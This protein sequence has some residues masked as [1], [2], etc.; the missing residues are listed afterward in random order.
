M[1]RLPIIVLALSGALLAG[2]SFAQ[3]VPGQYV[4]PIEGYVNLSAGFCDFRTRHYHG[5]IDLSTGGQEG[6][7]IRA[8]D[9][10]WVSRVSVGFW[11]YGKAIYIQMTDGRIA[12]YGHLSEL[13]DKIQK[14][15]EDEQYRSHRYQQNLF[16]ER[17]QIPIARGE[18]IGKSGQT[19]AGPPHLH[20]EIRTGDNKPL[21]PLSFFDKPDAIK[22]NIH[23][24]TI[25]PWQPQ[26][27]ETSP[28][29]VDGSLLYKTFPVT[30]GKLA[31]TP[32]VTGAVGISV[33]ADDHID[34]RR[35]TKSAFRHRLIANGDVIGEVRYDSINYDDTRQIEIERRYDPDGG[36]SPRSVNLF[37][38][39]G[40]SLWHYHGFKGNGVLSRDRGLKTGKNS[41]RIEVEDWAGNRSAIEFELMLDDIPA[42]VP[43]GSSVDGIELIPA[44]G[45]GVV[46]LPRTSGKPPEIALDAKSERRIV[47][48]IKGARGW[49]AWIPAAM[50]ADQLWNRTSGAAMPLNWKPIRSLD[51]GLVSSP[52]GHATVTISPGDIY[53]SGFY[54]LVEGSPGEGSRALTRLYTFA[55]RN[56]PMARD[57][58]L[59]I[60]LPT[61]AIPVEK[62]AIYRG[63]G[64]RWTFE[65]KERA[66][67]LKA[68][69]ATIRSAGSFAIL[70]DQKSPVIANVTPGKGAVISQRR[71]TIRFEVSDNLSGI[72]SD[73]DL[74]MTIDGQWVPVEY[75]PDL[76]AAKARPR[77]DLD[78][79]VH[80]VEIVARDRCGNEARFERR[81]TV[82]K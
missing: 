79:G 62:L 50:D 46:T 2:P 76:R 60:D 65:G 54:S 22:P 71:P 81:I 29:T 32:K 14:Y 48:W 16:P 59:T 44:W 37:R 5:G 55:P 82:R 51:G 53:V 11:G 23:S 58:S 8:A 36:L 66:S 24:V 4:W 15:V 35:W 7:P 73:E 17:R 19:G 31:S 30:G 27:L 61:T 80:T 12:V 42:S 10:G 45:G 21:N 70:A 72:G 68:L 28:S 25:T 13:S 9:S 78:P 39:E 38:W 34:A 63:L 49:Q 26:T 67:D 74:Q 75:D 43:A 40:N 20:F 33:L 69:M 41:V 47:H 1:G 57:V 56:I 77:W 64:T 52:D 3:E 6:L 18:V